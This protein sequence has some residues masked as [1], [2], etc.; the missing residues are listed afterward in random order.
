MAKLEAFKELLDKLR[1]RIAEHRTT[2]E[3]NEAAVRRQLIEPLL[4]FFDWDM[5]N[6]LQ[7]VPEYSTESGHADYGLNIENEKKPNLFVEAKAMSKSPGKEAS[8]LSRYCYDEGVRYG[9]ISN[10]KQWLLVRSFEENV[11]ARKR[12]LWEVDI[13]D[14]PDEEIFA[15]LSQIS[16]ENLP[17]LDAIVRQA[18]T[19][20]GIAERCLQSSSPEIVSGICSAVRNQPEFASLSCSN[21]ELEMN[22]RAKLASM[23]G[24]TQAEDYT[25]PQPPDDKKQPRDK[26]GKKAA[27]HRPEAIVLFDKRISIRFSYEI[28]TVVASELVRRGALSGNKVPFRR[29]YA[30]FLVSNSPEHP[31]GDKFK[32]PKEVGKGVWIEGHCSTEAAIEYAK[33]LLEHCSYKASDLQIIR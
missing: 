31:T 15:K 1:K 11:P 26:T 30:C 29:G 24:T 17:E 25:P 27:P 14:D 4:S 23:L 8:Q 20:E 5:E 21:D 3:N 12:N 6:L 32:L 9:V 16:R 19:L 18:K 28:L 7:V 22:V 2:Y 13:V 10:G 33:K